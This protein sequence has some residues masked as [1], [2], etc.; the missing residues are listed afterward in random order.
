MRP[1]VRS[2]EELA[3]WLEQ[4]GVPTNGWSRGQAKSVTDLFQELE[5]GECELRTSPL[6]RVLRGVAELLIAQ[7]DAVLIEARQ[8]FGDGRYRKR[9]TLPAEKMR[10]GEDPL[11]AARRCVV[12]ELGRPAGAISSL[13]RVSTRQVAKESQ[14]YPGLLTEYTFHQVAVAVDGLPAGDFATSELRSRATDD[15]VEKH[16]WTWREEAFANAERN[17]YSRDDRRG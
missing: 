3:L 7:G 9:G 4:R 12:E 6:K 13:E 11:T 14:S 15:P 17:L 16:F 10:A 2:P 1:D 5:A 8:E